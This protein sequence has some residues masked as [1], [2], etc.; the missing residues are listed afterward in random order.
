MHRLRGGRVGLLDRA[1][2]RGRQRRREPGGPERGGPLDTG[3]GHPARARHRRHGGGDERH[4]GRRPREGQ[5]APARAP[6]GG[7]GGSA[8]RSPGSVVG[9]LAGGDRGG[10]R[11]GDGRRGRWRARSRP[12]L[13]R[14]GGRDDV[15]GRVPRGA[16]RLE[17]RVAGTDVLA[18]RLPRREPVAPG[19]LVQ[20]RVRDGPRARGHR[21]VGRG[22]GRLA[23]R[24]QVLGEGADGRAAGGPVGVGHDGSPL[25][26]GGVGADATDAR[27]DCHPGSGEVDGEASPPL[28]R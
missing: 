9:T 15:V 18:H 2:R 7:S 1:A 19:G 14:A 5:G 3:S 12:V 21:P 27:R 22:A 13:A 10:R 17:V 16:G 11:P 24:T 26:P 8:S 4:G 6:G 28:V 23:H 20:R 25:V